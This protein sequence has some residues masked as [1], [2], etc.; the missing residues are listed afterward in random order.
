MKNQHKTRHL[1]VNYIHQER[2][3][4][5][6]QVPSISLA[7]IWVQNAGFK[8]GDKVMVDVEEN[9]IVIS[10]L[11]PDPSETTPEKA[12]GK[13]KMREIRNALI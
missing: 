6:K 11:K 8:I 7:G 13:M 10:R 9:R 3:Y 4:E 2:T 1:T 5:C 12:N